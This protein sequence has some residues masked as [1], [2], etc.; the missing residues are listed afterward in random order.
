MKFKCHAKSQAGSA[1]KR[2]SNADSTAQCNT[3]HVM[4][5]FRSLITILVTILQ[6]IGDS[7]RPLQLH[8]LLASPRRVVFRICVVLVTDKTPHPTFRTNLQTAFLTHMSPFRTNDRRRYRRHTRW[9]QYLTAR[10]V[11]RPHADIAG[12]LLTI[13]TIRVAR[14]VLQH[15]RPSVTHMASV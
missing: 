8:H 5:S 2:V 6:P 10:A 13:L 14:Q 15:F 7:F 11:T 3:K 9:V 1:H 12:P 4:K